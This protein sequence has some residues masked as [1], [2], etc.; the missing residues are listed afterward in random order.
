MALKICDP[1]LEISTTLEISKVQM[2]V[3][4]ELENRI[5]RLV[6]MSLYSLIWD[7]FGILRQLQI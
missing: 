3:Q 5:I 7:F 1:T 4:T 6:V 2:C